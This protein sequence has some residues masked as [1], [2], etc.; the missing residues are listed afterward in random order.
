MTIV[1]DEQDNISI[2]NI[3]IV[4]PIRAKAYGFDYEVIRHVVGPN[5]I[6]AWFAVRVGE[7][8][9]VKELFEIMLNQKDT[10]GEKP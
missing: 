3:T 4:K 9:T 2:Q 7:D 8:C 1:K 6:D 5:G 10:R